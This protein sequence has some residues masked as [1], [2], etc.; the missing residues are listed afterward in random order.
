M[1]VN[2]KIKNDFYLMLA[3]KGILLALSTSLHFT[4]TTKPSHPLTC[5]CYRLYLTFFGK[6]EYLGKQVGKS[7]K[8]KVVSDKVSLFP[9]SPG[10]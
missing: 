8:E 10:G 2:A 7:L 6:E 3:K 4:Y 9:P 1:S 5:I